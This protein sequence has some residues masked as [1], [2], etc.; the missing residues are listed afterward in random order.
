MGYLEYEGKMRSYWQ[1]IQYELHKSLVSDKIDIE[2]IENLKS[3]LSE[4]Q[5]SKVI[6]NVEK[7]E[8]ISPEAQTYISEFKRK[9]AEAGNKVGNLSYHQSNYYTYLIEKGK[10]YNF[11]RNLL[12]HEFEEIYTYMEENNSEAYERLKDYINVCRIL[13]G[14]KKE[15]NI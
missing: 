13:L 8:N 1:R 12:S 6:F 15:C 4:F 2:K 11:A 5:V 3:Q 10:G 7:E 9:W 14:I